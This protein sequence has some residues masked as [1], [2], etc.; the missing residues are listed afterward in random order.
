MRSS[1]SLNYK[2]VDLPAV[3]FGRWPVNHYYSL[4]QLLDLSLDQLLDLES[5][6]DLHEEIWAGIALSPLIAGGPG[7][8]HPMVQG[9]GLYAAR[10]QYYRLPTDSPLRRSGDRVM[11]EGG[12]AALLRYI[13][14]A[15]G[16]LNFPLVIIRDVSDVLDFNED[17]SGTS[18]CM[19][20]QSTIPP[21]AISRS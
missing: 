5:L 14:D 13:A 7:I 16:A 3:D 9:H 11:R 15:M 1:A 2:S 10:E 20:K 12:P 21:L 19:T 4:D 6:R 17:F 18:I 8:L